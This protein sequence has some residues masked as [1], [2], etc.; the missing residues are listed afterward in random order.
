MRQVSPEKKWLKKKCFTTVSTPSP[1]SHRL[2]RMESTW[3][4]LVSLLLAAHL[5]A[6]VLTEGAP[7]PT[8]VVTQEPITIPFVKVRYIIRQQST[9]VYHVDTLFHEQQRGTGL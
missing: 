2:L 4:I 6:T 7:T 8:T 1:H 9:C 3:L 5:L